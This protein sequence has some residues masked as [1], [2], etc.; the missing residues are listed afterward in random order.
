M[1]SP[2]H[3]EIKTRDG[4]TLAYAEYGSPVGQPIIYCHGA[5]SSRVEADLIVN[6]ATAFA[7]DLRVIVPDRPGIGRSDYQVDRRII[8]WPDDVLDLTQ[9]LGVERF[10][11]LGSSGGAPYAAV[12]GARMPDR[13]RAIG[14]VGAIAPPDAPGMLASM[15]GPLRM[16]FRLS[17]MAPAVLRGLFRLNLRAMRRGGDRARTR[18]AAWAPEPD[19]RLLERP[20]VANGFMACFEEACRQ[21]P[22]GAVMD[23]G[24]IAGPWGFDLTTLQAS[25]LLWHGEHDRKVPVTHGRYLAGTIPRCRATFLPNDAHLSVPLNHQEEILGAL[26]AAVTAA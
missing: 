15:S 26:A 13:V 21:G 11:V 8:D 7:L 18:M 3:R 17:R 6:A 12:C 24:L 20:E 22:R 16:M 2:A 4:R 25:V 5:P 9:A 14:L 1:A 23:V 10:A 19:R